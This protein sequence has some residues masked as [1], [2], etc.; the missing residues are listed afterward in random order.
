[1]KNP[2]WGHW[3]DYPIVSHVK[4]K[5]GPLISLEKKG[6]I[7]RVGLCFAPVTL[8]TIRIDANGKQSL[9]H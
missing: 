9:K 5:D 4:Q 3:W 8:E 1:M 2:R 6:V 7:P